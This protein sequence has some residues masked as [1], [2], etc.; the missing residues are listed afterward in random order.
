M[1]RGA[2]TVSPPLATNWAVPSGAAHY[3][4]LRAAIVGEETS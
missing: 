3:G 1:Q 2:A 4:A